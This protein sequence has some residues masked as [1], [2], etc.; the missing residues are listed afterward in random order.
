[1]NY[2]HNKSTTKQTMEQPKVKLSSSSTLPKQ[3]QQQ[4]C[5]P[6][7]GKKK[8][9]KM[10]LKRSLAI[11][12]GQQQQKQR[13]EEVSVPSI[14]KEV[15]KPALYNEDIGE[16]GIKKKQKVIVEPIAKFSSSSSSSSLNNKNTSM[17]SIAMSM[18]LTKED[19]L[20]I[21]ERKVR[22]FFCI[23]I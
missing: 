14:I 16:I 9:K 8:T 19:I 13:Q 12:T 22:K 6:T 20:K 3:Q 21:K 7:T 23:I 15:E 2:E 4:Q 5:S 18:K 17:T 11:M 10:M 1:V